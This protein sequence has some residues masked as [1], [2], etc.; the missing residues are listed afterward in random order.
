MTCT[1][2]QFEVRGNFYNRGG[3][4]VVFIFQVV[5]GHSK[6]T[7]NFVLPSLVSQ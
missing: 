1:A 5:T 6:I 2:R 4:F 3:K 7:D